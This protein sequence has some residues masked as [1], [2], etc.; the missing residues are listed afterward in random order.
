MD[1]ASPLI[2]M[3]P[4]L[5]GH[6]L[7]ACRDTRAPAV[8]SILENRYVMHV[9]SGRAA[10]ALALE[11]SGVATGD[12]VL[13]PAY[14]CESM[15]SPTK[16]R[17]AKPIFYKINMRAEIDVADIKAKITA[18]TKAII[19]THY[20]GFIQDML[21]ITELCTQRNIILIE[22]C[23]HA[24]FGSKNGKAV[25]SWGS[26]A[27]ASSMKF[28]P[29][30]D[31]GVLASNINPNDL[32]KIGAPPLPF[33]IKSALNV[34]QTAIG[35]QRLGIVGKIL[36][37][38]NALS[39]KSWKITKK[40]MG[41]EGASIAGPSSSGGGYG[42][43]EAWIHRRA[44]VF[45]KRI[46]AHQKKQRIV[47]LRRTNYL[48]LHSALATL[49]NS[50][51][52]FES[53]PDEVVPL[54]FPLYVEQPEKHFHTL[55]SQGVPIWRFGEFLDEEVTD[56]VCGASTNLSAHVFQF[57]CHQELTDDEIAW[58]I[59]RITAELTTKQTECTA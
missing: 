38:L 28:F 13:I 26:Y 22:D 31:G 11:R 18:Q 32:E 6:G 1:Y 17:G 2:P 39:E 36:G 54:V 12:E 40:I 8:H 47:E 4:V 27:I 34:I 43:D 7:Q 9:T 33:Q 45:S 25:G 42:L 48:R 15:V 50:R 10:I 41:R 49:P 59:E 53:L 44:T 23:A 21:A 51:A 37:G 16:W 30:Y 20:F 46:I 19:V 5:S 56:Q 3:S 24:F 57:P 14:H 35:Y 52:L 55:K 58:M 29:V